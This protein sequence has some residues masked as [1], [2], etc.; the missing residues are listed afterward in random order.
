MDVP[1][2]HRR[3]RLVF[4]ALG[5]GA[6]AL[7]ET[8]LTNRQ[9]L[10]RVGGVVIS[11]MGLLLAGVLRLPLLMREARLDLSRVRPGPAGAVPSG[12]HSRSG[13]CRALA[14]CWRHS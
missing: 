1:A 6:S 2:V 7:S 9:P 12:W 13:R 8:L 14:R 3:L 11:I 4:T 5:A 10:S